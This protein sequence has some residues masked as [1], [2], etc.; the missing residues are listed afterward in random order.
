MSSASMEAD[1]Y[2]GVSLNEAIYSVCGRVPP[3]SD[4]EQMPLDWEIVEYTLGEE[5]H[6]MSEEEIDDFVKSI[7]PWY[8][9]TVKSVKGGLNLTTDLENAKGYAG[10]KGAVLAVNVEGDAVAF[11]D[12]YLYAR[13]SDDAKVISI[14]YEGKQ[15][16]PE[17]FLKEVGATCLLSPLNLNRLAK[18]VEE[19]Q[20]QR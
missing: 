10:E 18:K 3:S 6:S 8:D 11:S 14:Y 19:K 7:V 2:R 1:G 5:A 20:G 15:F 4:L 13:K 12:D 16:T 9:G 17:D